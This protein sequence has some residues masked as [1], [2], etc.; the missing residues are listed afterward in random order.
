MNMKS[1]R[2]GEKIFL[3]RE[4]AASASFLPSRLRALSRLGGSI[5]ATSWKA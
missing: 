3:V 5:V 1:V 2:K 4:A